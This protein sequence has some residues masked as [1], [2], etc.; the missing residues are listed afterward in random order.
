MKQMFE[1][2]VSLDDLF[3]VVNQRKDIHQNV[4]RL[5]FEAGGTP[6]VAENPQDV[7]IL[8]G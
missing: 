6:D 7:D 3:N 4:L 2:G 8:R 1:A 5:F